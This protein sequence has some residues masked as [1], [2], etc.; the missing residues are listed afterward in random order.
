MI[1]YNKENKNLVIPNGLGNLNGLADSYLDAARE[2]GREEGRNEVRELMTELHVTSNATYINKNGFNKVVV[3][4]TSAP[5]VDKDYQ[6][7]FNDGYARAE[8]DF[9]LP[10]FY[11]D[12]LTNSEALYLTEIENIMAIR[13][14]ENN[15]STL[16]LL[17]DTIFDKV[18]ESNQFPISLP[19]SIRETFT[20]DMR[21]R[22]LE[23][24]YA[25]RG[26]SWDKLIY[27]GGFDCQYFQT[28][29]ENAFNGLSCL[30]L[31]MNQLGLNFITEQTLVTPDLSAD[32]YNNSMVSDTVLSILLELVDSLYDFSTPNIYGVNKSYIKFKGFKGD[33]QALTEKAAAKNW[34]VVTE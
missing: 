17:D 6:E 30:V 7:G 19:L 5:S 15:F 2:D 4:V 25:G 31:R 18:I 34:T 20:F 16:G 21:Q 24:F 26:I 1:V 33:L 11:T 28:I 13:L 8:K 32:I 29:S 14:G 9:K 3:N 23:Q 22:D 27:M 12:G 10:Y